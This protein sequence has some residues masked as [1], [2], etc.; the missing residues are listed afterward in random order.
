MGYD[1]QKTEHAGPKK[2]NGAYW[3]P[4]QDAKKESNKM[5]RRNAKTEIDEAAID[6]Q[7]EAEDVPQ[8]RDQTSEGSCQSF[9]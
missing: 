8:E 7:G 2:G 1:A 5:R 4:K 3:S 6:A 9:F